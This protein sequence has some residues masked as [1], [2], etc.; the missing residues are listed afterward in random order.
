MRQ[1]TENR[2]GGSNIGSI[3]KINNL[4][5]AN[6]TVLMAISEKE[7]CSRPN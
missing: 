7:L 3:K 2:E 1:V 6:D 4:S 5:Y